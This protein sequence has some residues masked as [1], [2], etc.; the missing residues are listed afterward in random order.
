MKTFAAFCLSILFLASCSPTLTETAN[1]SDIQLEWELVENQFEGKNQYKARFIISNNSGADLQ[2]DWAIY[3]NGGGG[4]VVDDETAG[5]KLEYIMGTF[6]K[7]APTDAFAGLKAGESISFEYVTGGAITKNSQKPIG[8][9]IVDKDGVATA[10]TDFNTTQLRLDHPEITKVVSRALPTPDNL[11]DKNAALTQLAANELPRLI[12]TPLSVKA[13]NGSYTLQAPVAIFYQGDLKNEADFLKEELSKV[14]TGE[15]TVAE[16]KGKGIN[17]ALKA[18]GK[19]ESYTLQIGNGITIAGKDA[20]GVFYGIQTLRALLPLETHRDKSSAITLE[21]LTINDA[22]RFTYRGMHLDVGRNFMPKETVMKLMNLMAYYKL[23]YFHFHLTE[24]EG[25]RI[26]IPGLPELTQIGGR[27]GHT[28][29]EEEFLHP[30]YG[31]GPDPNDPSSPGNGFYSR[32]DFVEILKH[33]NSRNIKV[34]PEIDIPGHSRAAIVAMKARYN[35]LMKEGKADEAN[36]Y[37]LHDPEDQSEYLSIQGFPDNVI[38]VCRPSALTFME[39]VFDEFIAMYKEAEAPLESIHVGGDEVPKGVWEKSPICNE[40]MKQHPE[41][42]KVHDLMPY[43]IGELIKMLEKKGMPTSGWQEIAMREA[44]GGGEEVNPEFANTGMRPYVWLT[45]PDLPYKIANAGYTPIISNAS[46]LYFD[47]AY[48][49]DPQEP[50]Q[51]WAGLVNTRTAWEIV[52]FNIYYSAEEDERGRPYNPEEKLKSSVRLTPEGEKNILGIQGQLWTEV[53]KTPELLE[54]FV[55]PKFLGLAER[56]WAANPSWAT[57]AN[58]AQ[59]QKARE[60]AWNVFANSLG[61]KELPRLDYLEGGVLYQIPRPGVKIENGQL[62]VNTEFPGLI[63][64]YTTDGTEPTATS[65]QWT[66]PVAVSGTVKVKSFDSKG[67]SGLSSAV[68]PN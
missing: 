12:P 21:A 10:F 41:M 65:P 57:T 29:T 8:A 30:E 13:G 45:D 48:N 54:H 66:G 25:W 7:L 19:A 4:A 11:Y 42:T 47:L 43:F 36:Q 56:A 44:E 26:E 62:L 53:A 23:N 40:F 50:G 2:K 1:L 32:A 20:A 35:R 17:L 49:N 59:R 24:D 5:L 15:I 31:S 16:G 67:R 51:T 46:K 60:A 52:P 6:F 38:C 14:V 34:I 22:P 37:A 61:Q 55:F 9:Y 3:F 39:K 64:R 63:S 68:G 28:T 27:R 33:A 18:D 58:L